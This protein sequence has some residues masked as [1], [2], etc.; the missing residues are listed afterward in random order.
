MIVA[1]QTRMYLLHK[2]A[3]G[4][5]AIEA[6]SAD[7]RIL[8]Q[9][10]AEVVGHQVGFTDSRIKTAGPVA[11]GDYIPQGNMVLREF[12]HTFPIIPLRSRIE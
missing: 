12:F 8:L 11:G 1:I 7:T 6:D 9:E 5:L 4:F 10:A 3:G 2:K